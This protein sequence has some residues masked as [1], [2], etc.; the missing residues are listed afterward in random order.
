MQERHQDCGTR[1]PALESYWVA[2]QHP[3][4][5]PGSSTQ[6]GARFIIVINFPG[7]D[8]RVTSFSP[9]RSARCCRCHSF[10]FIII[11]FFRLSFRATVPQSRSP[12]GASLILSPRLAELRRAGPSFDRPLRPDVSRR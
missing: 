2:A 6:R 3:G 5:H 8:T 9:I 4:Q 11:I 7:R 1:L 10:F 12:P